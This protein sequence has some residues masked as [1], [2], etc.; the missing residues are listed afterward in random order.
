[1][2]TTAT[3]AGHGY[4]RARR[5]GRPEARGRHDPGFRCRPREGV[6]WG[7]GWRLDADFTTAATTRSSSRRR[8][9]SARF[10]SARTSDR[11]ARTAQGLLLIVSDIQAARKDLVARCRGERG[12]PLRRRPSLGGRVSGPAPDRRATARSC[13]S[14]TRTATAGCCRR[15]RPGSPAVWRAT[16]R[17]TSASDLAQAFRR[18]EAAHGEHEKRT[19]QRDADWPDWYAEYMVR[20]QAG[21][22]CR[23]ELPTVDAAARQGGIPRGSDHVGRA[24]TQTTNGSFQWRPG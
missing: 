14:T 16:R 1:M 21:T 5:K 17:Y 3:P 4:R 2:S 12:V 9:P 11:R 13:R 24:R 15:S 7:L 10:T 8:A 6:L 19:G 22:S 23:S 20:E 18:A